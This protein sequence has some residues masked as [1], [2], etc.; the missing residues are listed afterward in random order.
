MKNLKGQAAIERTS[1]AARHLK[2]Q[3]AM[4]YLMTYGWALLAIV[5]VIA[6]LIYLNPFRAPEICLFQQQ[7]FSCSEPNPQLFVDSSGDLNMNVRIWNKLGQGV[8]IED[9]LCTSAPGGEVDRDDAQ[10]AGG[11]RISTG[12]SYTFEG[13]DVVECMGADGDVIDTMGAGNEFRGRLVIWYNYEDDIDMDIQHQAQ[14]NVISLVVE[15]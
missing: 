14:A 10:D 9:I 4:E 3:A 13:S 5:I 12:G 1:F 11:A 7:G 8:I 6:A 2:G 15:G